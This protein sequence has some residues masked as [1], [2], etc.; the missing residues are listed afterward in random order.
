MLRES[1]DKILL[2]GSIPSGVDTVVYLWSCSHC[3]VPD[4]FGLAYIGA[5]VIADP[6][7]R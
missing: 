4:E 6:D 7:C 5:S 2:L 3:E 1:I